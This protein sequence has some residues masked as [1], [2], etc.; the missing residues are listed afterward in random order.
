MNQNVL[1]LPASGTCKIIYEHSIHAFPSHYIYRETPYVAFREKGGFIEKLYTVRDCLVLIPP[2]TPASADLTRFDLEIQER[3]LSYIQDRKKGF[4]FEKTGQT[5]MFWILDLETPLP[6]RPKVTPNTPG[7]QYFA[8]EDFISREPVITK[9]G[10]ISKSGVFEYDDFRDNL[11][12]DKYNS[13][14][15]AMRNMKTKHLR[16]ENSEDAITWNVFKSLQQIN[17]QHW[18]PELIAKGINQT[19]Y[20]IKKVVPTNQLPHNLSINLWKTIKPPSTLLDNQLPEGPTEVDVI[21]ESENVVWF[22]EAKFKSDISI[23]T[24]HNHSRNQVLRNIDVGS[25]Y[26][27]G[28]D[29]YFSLLILEDAMS[30]KGVSA[31][32]TYSSELTSNTQQFQRRFRSNHL[33][34]VQGITV[35]YWND[36]VEIFKNCMQEVEDDFEQLIAA[37]AFHWMT[38]KVDQMVIN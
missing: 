24:T 33:S 14:L 26:A 10:T 22:I 16:S 27:K 2:Y 21:I 30:S 38:E 34:N 28:K 5:Y 9:N 7:H 1:T 17:P 19:K 37:R 36:F 6:H 15:P 23:K 20:A 32:D 18:Y 13:I 3:I 31:V 29:F 25:H 11:L 12:I 35:F 4:G 8:Y